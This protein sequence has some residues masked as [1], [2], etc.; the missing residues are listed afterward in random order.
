MQNIEQIS[1]SWHNATLPQCRPLY[2]FIA[3]VENVGTVLHGPS[4][5]WTMAVRTGTIQ[6]TMKFTI[7]V[8]SIV[9]HDIHD[10]S[11]HYAFNLI[12]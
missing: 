3:W 11:S 7:Y 4:T 9:S 2:R 6:L 1:D 5:I 12:E 10:T 8:I